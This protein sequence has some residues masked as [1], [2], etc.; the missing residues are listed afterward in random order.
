M[1]RPTSAQVRDLQAAL[2]AWFARNRRRFPWRRGGATL[3]EIIVAE[4]L[5]QRTRADV[6]AAFLPDF[7]R[8]YSS[9]RKLALASEDD[10]GSFLRP[11][12]L[13][14]RR[15]ASLRALAGAMQTARGRFPTSRA[16]IERLPGVGQYIAN[17]ICLF[18]H[19]QSEPLLDVN[20]ARVLERCFG[21]RALVDIRYDAG[22][23][24]VARA[25]VA[26]KRAPQLNWAILDLAA[27]VCRP[28]A[29]A[30]RLCPISKVCAVGRRG[31]A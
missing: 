14:R 12:G 3:Y 5:L 25:V 27:L 29:P 1:H 23:Q 17:A 6:V 13:W 10:L 15:A 26:G 19:K 8:R 24:D 22:L 18:A 2:L 16:D 7:M 9:W 21:P 28:T 20:M 30:C 31:G 4:A 11:L